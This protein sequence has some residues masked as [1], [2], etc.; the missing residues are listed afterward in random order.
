MELTLSVCALVLA[1]C[2][3]LITVASRSTRQHFDAYSQCRLEVGQDGQ[4]RESWSF[5]SSRA[6]TLVGTTVGRVYIALAAAKF[7]RA[8]RRRSMRVN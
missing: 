6:N 2:A 8:E 5:H 4:E 3:L 7:D 1:I